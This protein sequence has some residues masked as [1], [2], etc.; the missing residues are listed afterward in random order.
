MFLQSNFWKKL[1]SADKINFG[2]SNVS[3]TV[4]IYVQHDPT[5]NVF[6]MSNKSFAC[7]QMND[8]YFLLFGGEKNFPFF[9]Q[10]HR[11]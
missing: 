4:R 9:A 7:E 5:K 1:F 2:S 11:L 8:T 6:A 10:W 3:G